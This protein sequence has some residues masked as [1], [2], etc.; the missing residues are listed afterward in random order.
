[1]EIFEIGEKVWKV[2]LIGMKPKISKNKS[3]KELLRLGKNVTDELSA[4]RIL[5]NLPQSIM[6]EESKL[7]E[8]KNIFDTQE[9]FH[10]QKFINF[11]DGVPPEKEVWVTLLEPDADPEYY[12]SIIATLLLNPLLYCVFKEAK[13][14]LKN[15]I[16]ITFDRKPK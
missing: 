16:V 9:F 10:Y 11:P 3:A 7:E 4:R 14:I 8:F 13:I 6:V 5:Q 2:A 1:M 15:G 12:F